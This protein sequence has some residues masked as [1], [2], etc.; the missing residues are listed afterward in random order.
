MTDTVTHQQHETNVSVNYDFVV[1]E[2]PRIRVPEAPK[3]QEPQ[4]F[5]EMSKIQRQIIVHRLI[6][7]LN[8][9]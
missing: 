3:V 6:D 1:N 7:R 5:V 2:F 8:E 4:N 9:I